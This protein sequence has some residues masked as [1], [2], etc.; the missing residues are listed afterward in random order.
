MSVPAEH[1]SLAY[2]NSIS[3]GIEQAEEAEHHRLSSLARP[4]GA[5]QRVAQPQTKQLKDLVMKALPKERLVAMRVSGVRQRPRKSATNLHG[6][7]Q[8]CQS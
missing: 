8:L 1:A 4:M 7:P 5:K 2:N 6:R 3:L